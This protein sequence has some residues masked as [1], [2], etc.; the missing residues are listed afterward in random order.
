[1]S[2]GNPSKTPQRKISI[3]NTA[4]DTHV[5]PKADRMIQKAAKLPALEL[6]PKQK[7]VKEAIKRE[8]DAIYTKAADLLADGKYFDAIELFDT[9]ISNKNLIEKHQL[10]IDKRVIKGAIICATS[11]RDGFLKGGVK[12]LNSGNKS[13]IFPPK[14]SPLSMRSNQAGILKHTPTKSTSPQ[15]KINTPQKLDAEYTYDIYKYDPKYE[16]LKI[17]AKSSQQRII[18]ALPYFA[19]AMEYCSYALKYKDLLPNTSGKM[20]SSIVTALK[21]NIGI[22]N[23]LAKSGIKEHLH[24]IKSSKAGKEAMAHFYREQGRLLN[25][26][27]PKRKATI[28]EYRKVARD[29]NLSPMLEHKGVRPIR[30]HNKER[31][32]LGIIKPDPILLFNDATDHIAKDWTTHRDPREREF[33]GLTLKLANELKFFKQNPQHL[34]ENNT[35]PL[36]LSESFSKNKTPDQRRREAKK[37]FTKIKRLTPTIANSNRRANDS[38]FQMFIG[39]IKSISSWK[40]LVKFLLK[41]KQNEEW[42]KAKESDRSVDPRAELHANLSALNL[43]IKSIKLDPT[44]QETFEAM[45]NLLEKIKFDDKIT[46]K[47]KKDINAIKGIKSLKDNKLAFAKLAKPLT[48]QI[49]MIIGI[50]TPSIPYTKYPWLIIFKGDTPKEGAGSDK[51]GFRQ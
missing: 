9:I 21:L 47:L 13:M 44:Q 22:S 11:I 19:R 23:L 50:N 17:R 7:R 40:A 46:K 1:M 31:R 3:G 4:K 27:I 12:M 38:K 30:I 33:S 45:L 16:Q 49:N 34:K 36:N 14:R 28:W 25:S 24:K 41:S 37:I 6:T 20:P 15:I 48:D 29:S 42:P 2:K 51:F 39:A 35:G 5:H 10:T 43:L 18:K 26:S 8:M 32:L